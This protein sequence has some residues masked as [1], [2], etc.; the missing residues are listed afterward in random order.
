M[1]E[2]TKQ[3]FRDFFERNPSLAELK[4]QLENAVE[5]LFKSTAKNKILVCGN[6]GSAADSEHIAG[7]LL[8]SFMNKRQVSS[9]FRD[10][11]VREFGEEGNFIADNLQQ[12]IKC[13]PL[14]SFCAF[15]TAFLN[16]CNEK[17]LFAQLVNALGDHG[18]VL[19]AIS[20]S[21]NSKN[22][23]Y[24]AQVAKIR[25]MKV[26]ALTGSG[27]GKLRGLCDVLLNVPSDIVYQIQELHLPVY[28]LLCL[29]L[30]NELYGTA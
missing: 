3:I 5:L 7:E 26:I 9:N 2:T 1:K 23:C 13:I 20:T 18:D 28:H 8:K 10:K 4:K 19:L 15:N 27:G 25:G 12:G 6:G 14:T 21:G 17:L 29:A 16:D 22:V 11:L 30:E 24:A